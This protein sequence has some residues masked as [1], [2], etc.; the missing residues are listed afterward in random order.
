MAVLAGAVFAVLAISIAPAN[1][2][3]G[4]YTTNGHGSVW[5]DSYGE[6]F[7]VNDWSADGDGVRGYL[8]ELRRGPGGQD[9]Y[10]PEKTLSNTNGLD[11]AATHSNRDIPEGRAVRYR[12]CLIDSAHDTSPHHCSGW[13]YDEA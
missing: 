13:K 10:Y 2:T 7:T 6:H 1:A 9:N 5:F 8:Q 12:V 4:V 11:G 3:G